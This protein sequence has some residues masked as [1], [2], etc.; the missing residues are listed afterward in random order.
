VSFVKNIDIF[1][2]KRL[3]LFQK[4]DP[5]NKVTTGP[6]CMLDSKLKNDLENIGCEA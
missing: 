3:V 1:L 2:K 4:H 5:F 6:C